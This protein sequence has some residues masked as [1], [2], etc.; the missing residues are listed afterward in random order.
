MRNLLAFLNRYHF[1][2]VFL[3]AQLICFWMM[4]RGKNYQG[5][6]LINSSNAVAA[7]IY[8]AEANTKEYFSLRQENLRLAIENTQL[9]NRMKSNYLAFPTREFRINDTVYKLQYEFIDAKVV[10]ASVNNRNNYITI[11]AGSA[12][13]VTKEMGVYNSLGMVGFVR[14]VSENFATIISILHKDF[15][16][17]CKLKRD[18]SYGPLIWDGKD[19]QYCLLTDIP[20]HAKI[21]NGDT[22]VSS[23]LSS[24]FPEGIMVGTIDSYERRQNEQFYTIKVKL[25]ADLKT[26][27]YVYVIK[28]SFKREKDS[29]EKTTQ[30]IK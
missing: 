30:P 10:N 28:N 12:Q 17:N 14:D 25:S 15:A 29:L 19:Y 3:L 20:T 24:Y 16:V 1:I 5:S 4:M 18:G 8:A 7:N 21:R 9:R 26:L 13:G 22:V 23:S 2:F 11:N 6:Q 27:N